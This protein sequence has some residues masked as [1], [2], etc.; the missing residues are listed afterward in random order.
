MRNIIKVKM[1]E[2]KLYIITVYLRIRKNLININISRR[3]T[4][5]YYVNDYVNSN[6]DNLTND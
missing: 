6:T 4:H 5:T 2:D 1:E 3:Y